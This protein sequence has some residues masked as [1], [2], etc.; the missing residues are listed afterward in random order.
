MKEMATIIAEAKAFGFSHVGELRCETIEL[1]PDVRSMCASGKC[2]IYDKNWA[3][4]PACGTL[5]ECGERINQFKSGIIVQ[6][7]GELEDALDGETMMETEA[8]HKETFL[9]FRAVLGEAYPELL[10]LGA[11][12]C[13]QCKVCSYPDSPCRFPQKAIS[14]M[15]AYGMLVTQVCQDNDIPYYYGDLTITY[16]SCYLLK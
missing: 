15:E 1:L 2:A 8:Q 12:A 16:T 14:S 5:A 9:K 4:P 11:G 10:A 6:T 3:C 7:T 13:Q